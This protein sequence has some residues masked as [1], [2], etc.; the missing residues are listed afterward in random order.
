MS[1]VSGIVER[2]IDLVSQFIALLKEE[3]DCLMQANP[4]L[5]PEL[6]A[7]KASLVD[8]MNALESERMAAIGQA[9][10]P[11]NRATMESWLTQNATDMAAVLNWNNLL[12]LAREAKGLHE[13]NG[14]LV[15]MHL[16]NTSE[17]LAILTPANRPSLYGA[18]GQ[19]MQDTGSRIVDSA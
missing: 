19:A 18:T 3:L 4:T 8:Q 16:R 1:I 2:E 9:G 5:L 12:D 15:E 11:S 14:R 10:S 13:Q 7:I 6:N 17:T